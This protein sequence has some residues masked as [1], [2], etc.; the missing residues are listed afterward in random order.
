MT[1]PTPARFLDT[2]IV[3]RHVLNDHPTHSPA[4]R[5][6][7]ASIERG[8]V[9]AWTTDLVVAEAVWVL[10]SGR[11]YNLARPVVRDGLL[12]VIEIPRLQFPSKR[13]YRRVFDLWVSLPIAFIDAVHATLIERRTP[14]ELYSFDAGFDRI[15]TVRRIEP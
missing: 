8:D 15:P 13:I 5:R 7:I 11:V 9:D 10:T 1:A 14:P 3:L 12:P 2:N 6:L 4:C